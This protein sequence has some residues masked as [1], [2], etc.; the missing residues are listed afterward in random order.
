MIVRRE[1]MYRVPVFLSLQFLISF[2]VVSY[3][4]DK[5]STSAHY[6]PP[7]SLFI[8]CGIG[9]M[10]T[11]NL[12]LGLFALQVVLDRLAHS[13]P[14]E[15]VSLRRYWPLHILF[16]LVC[17]LEQ[18]Y[19]Q[20]SGRQIQVEQQTV[21]YKDQLMQ[22]VITTTAQEERNRLA[23]D[24]HDSIK[25]QIFSITMS[26]AAAKARWEHDLTRVRSILDDI[27]RTAREAQVE[28]QAM[29]QQLR[30]RALENTGLVESLRMQSQA[31]EYR[32]G[33]S[34]TVEIG[35]LPSEEHLPPGL[36]EVL[37]RIVQEGFANIARHARASH[38]WLSLY[39][40]QEFLLL[41]IG[42]DGQGFDISHIPG[43]SGSG[44]MGMPNIHERMRAFHG[45]VQIWSMPDKGTTLQI[46][47]P[48]LA[49]SE[50]ALEAEQQEPELTTTKHARRLLNV[51]LRLIDVAAV[52]ILLAVPISI[53]R[54]VLGVC[55]FLVVSLW[56]GTQ[57]PRMQVALSLGRNHLQHVSLMAQNDKLL[58]SLFLVGIF[59]LGCIR[60]FWL[61]S[62]FLFVVIVLA[63]AL[64][65]WYYVL[66]SRFCQLLTQKELQK[67]INK[68][69]QQ[70]GLDLLAWLITISGAAFFGFITLDLHSIRFNSTM[71]TQNA[72]LSFFLLWFIALML[73]GI[74]TLYWQQLLVRRSV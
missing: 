45:T 51:G 2:F 14:V 54:V 55:L 63:L 33:A 21:A 74:E 29:L 37:F 19:G 39:Q 58:L 69:Q 15:L 73:K 64:A 41:E 22:Q 11:A 26:A 68:Q 57:V 20:Q 47:I 4:V 42:D 16:Q 27:E 56:L 35:Q 44:G 9:L 31:L 60:Y 65:V 3:V 10:L 50:S 24:L 46:A 67:F 12:S 36:Q 66:H 18:Q 40:Q 61:F 13:L 59:Y 25:Q 5:L 52:C 49:S 70:V 32:T 34:M 7:I 17:E 71:W 72:A 38:V 30:P 48:L 53:E 23:R 8:G 6:G 1:K 62:W 43:S 28:M